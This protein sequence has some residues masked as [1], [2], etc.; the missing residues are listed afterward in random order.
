VLHTLTNLPTEAQ[1]HGL[2]LIE[3]DELNAVPEIIRLACVHASQHRPVLV[4]PYAISDLQRGP[5]WFHRSLLGLGRRRKRAVDAG[6]RLQRQPHDDSDAPAAEPML[7]AAATLRGYQIENDP[8]FDL[9]GFQ[10]DDSAIG[11]PGVT[12]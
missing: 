6:Q 1:P 4:V 11:F 3:R 9:A 10:A 5:L 7:I 2:V 8:V 12:S